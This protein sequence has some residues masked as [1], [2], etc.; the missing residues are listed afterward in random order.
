MSGT[1][2]KT[3]NERVLNN[4]VQTETTK[5]KHL[6]E[7]PKSLKG[8]KV[9]GKQPINIYNLNPTYGEAKREAHGAVTRSS[10]TAP[11]QADTLIRMI[12]KE[13]RRKRGFPLLIHS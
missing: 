6:I 5:S 8:N 12:D 11:I 10:P 3:L 9:G 4:R 7:G 2:S 13:S 1:S